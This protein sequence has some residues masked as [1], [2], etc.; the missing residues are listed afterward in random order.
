MGRLA[1]PLPYSTISW[2]IQPQKGNGKTEKENLQILCE[3]CNGDKSSSMTIEDLD[4]VI[5][6]K[7]GRLT[8]EQIKKISEILN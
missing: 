8:S 6:T 4:K 5:K 2:K 3:D 1:S 7:S